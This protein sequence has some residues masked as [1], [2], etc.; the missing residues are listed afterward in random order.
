[1]GTLA[2]VG[3]KPVADAIGGDAAA[4]ATRRPLTAVWLVVPWFAVYAVS[5]ERPGYAAALR[6]VSSTEFAALAAHR[7]YRNPLGALHPGAHRGRP[8]RRDAP[9]LL[10]PIR[11]GEK[12]TSHRPWDSFS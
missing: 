9:A 3:M 8:D 4:W 7:A 1:M 12:R 10:S 2:A 11:S 6:W 5:F